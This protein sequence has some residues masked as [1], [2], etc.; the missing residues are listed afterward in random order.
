MA[1]LLAGKFHNW[2]NNKL[3]VYSLS[4]V[5]GAKLGGVAQVPEDSKQKTKPLEEIKKVSNIEPKKEFKEVISDDKLSLKKKD[6]VA[7]P[8]PT[9]SATTTSTPTPTPTQ[10]EVKKMT[11][12]PL[13]QPSKTQAIVPSN[14]PIPATPTRITPPTIAPP[15]KIP[16]TL[17]PS[18]TFT[19]VVKLK[20]ENLYDLREKKD[21]RAPQNSEAQINKDYKKKID[22]YIGESNRA[23]GSGYGAA[24][25]GGNGS[26]GGK[27]KPREFFIYLETIQR[28]VKSN[29]RWFDPNAKFKV[30]VELGIS[31]KGDIDY[32][33]IVEPSISA[34]FDRS[35]MR[36]L[37]AAD[38]LPP[39]P[40]SVYKD[41]KQV[42]IVFDPNM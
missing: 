35:V 8:K 1:T 11:P 21:V 6:F 25:Q 16:P 32:A 42:T 17:I 18:L 19:P 37:E 12:T 23:G 31:P 20:S 34:E 29:W 10:V 2:S 7:T 28:E 22:Q 3:E 24:S 38:P 27:V 4:V 41:F 5:S 9:L 14:T 30:V 36:A 39:P 40:A 13:P 33:R 26:G 15:T